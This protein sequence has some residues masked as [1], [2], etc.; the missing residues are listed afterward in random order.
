MQ[1][2]TQKAFS[3]GS[4]Q[5]L[6]FGSHLKK[7]FARSLWPPIHTF[8]S[9]L[10]LVLTLSCLF[11]L[12]FLSNFAKG[13]SARLTLPLPGYA[14]ANKRQDRLWQIIF[15]IFSRFQLSNLFFQ[16]RFDGESLLAYKQ[17]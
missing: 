8:W 13:A 16:R 4:E 6:K 12:D 2:D 5:V 14:T 11:E 3:N 1:N 7:Y 15:N 10:K 9:S 17:R